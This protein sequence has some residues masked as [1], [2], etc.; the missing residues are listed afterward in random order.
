VLLA[1]F[2]CYLLFPLFPSTPPRSFFHDLPGPAARPLFRKTNF[3]ILEQYGI[4][5]SVFPSGHVAAVTATALTLRS[6]LPRAGLAFLT[7][8]ASIAAATVYG[9]YHYAADALA[10]ATIGFA[11]FLSAS[12]IHRPR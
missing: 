6:Y 12:Y 8:A 5:S 3:W 7:A 2:W 9:R 1:L 11:A 10:G 4:Q